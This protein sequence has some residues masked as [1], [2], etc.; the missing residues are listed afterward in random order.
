MPANGATPK[1]V[2][3]ESNAMLEF[4]NH[5]LYIIHTRALC[6][7]GAWL[8]ILLEES[9]C[10]VLSVEEYLRGA[11]PFPVTSLC[12]RMRLISVHVRVRHRK[13][14]EEREKT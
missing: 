5:G 12:V 13:Q 1:S 3:I 2:M 14:E 6:C 7:F 11:R 8:Y 4:Y 9:L 10:E